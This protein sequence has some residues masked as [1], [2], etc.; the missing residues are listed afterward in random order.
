M[1]SERQGEILKEIV[2]QYIQKAK[3]I[4]SQMLKEDG[5]FKICPATLRNEMQKL[6]EKGYLK[7]PHISSGRVPTDKGYR[8]FV[9]CLFNETEKE[10]G[11]KSIKFEV[12]QELK[13]AMRDSLRV[14]QTLTRFISLK[15]SQIGVSYFKKE[16]I[17]WKEGW[18][19]IFKEPEFKETNFVLNLAKI[20]EDI[21]KSI[22]K[23]FSHFSFEVQVFIGK[24]NPFSKIKDF[25]IIATKC[26]LPKKGE[27]VLGIIGPKRMAYEKNINLIEN[28]VEFLQK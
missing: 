5:G 14:S 8:F 17:M 23:F 1:I 25:S 3:P 9:N 18:N 13:K 11:N 10:E 26:Y 22:E 21:E 12:E 19:E 7:K 28:I 6:T 24:E 27:G 4:S 16:K 2:K 20:I 15:S